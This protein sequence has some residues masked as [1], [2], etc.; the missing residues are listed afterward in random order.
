MK[1]KI[2]ISKWDKA[3]CNSDDSWIVYLH[4][5]ENKFILRTN[6]SNLIE[7]AHILGYTLMINDINI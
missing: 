1:F 3:I 2:R 6:Y 7:T 4:E 5:E